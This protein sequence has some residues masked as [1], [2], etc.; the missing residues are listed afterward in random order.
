VLLDF[1]GTLIDTWR[2]YLE[3]FRRSLQ[4]HFQRLLSDL[5][6]L[7]YQPIAERRLLH[8]IV[9]RGRVRDYFESFLAHYRSL[10]ETH[11]DG[12]YPG[13]TNMVNGLRAE[14]YA[15]GVV[16]GKSRDAWNTTFEYSKLAPFDVV[17]T[18]DDVTDP[19]PD[20]EGLIEALRVI[21]VEP[22]HAIYI[23]DSLLDC[24]AAHAAK[25]R[26]GAALWSKSAE[27]VDTFR[28]AV[29]ALGDAHYFSD[30]SAVLEGLAR[31]DERG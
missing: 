4:P 13:A 25:V 30:P 17:I 8:D 21:D 2:L 3:A 23:G 15:V 18:D 26:F 12:L 14:G 11:S 24:Q 5:E 19:K 20:P 22:S 29:G 31:R 1:D 27:E 16:T 7:A 6:I 9:E 28:K 10:H